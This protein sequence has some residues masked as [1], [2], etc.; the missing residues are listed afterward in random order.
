MSEQVK[1]GEL[2]IETSEPKTRKIVVKNKFESDL[3][4]PTI[5]DSKSPGRLANKPGLIKSEQRMSEDI[6][7]PL[8]QI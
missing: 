3:Y 6:Q 8:V 4:T 2:R 7:T 1:L 5:V